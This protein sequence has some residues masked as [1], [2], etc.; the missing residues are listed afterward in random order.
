MAADPILPDT[1]AAEKGLA[2]SQLEPSAASEQLQQAELARPS[3]ILTQGL[4]HSD[5]PLTAPPTNDDTRPELP[6]KSESTF[7]DTSIDGSIRIWDRRVAMPVATILPQGSPW[8]TGACWS[9][10]GNFFYA[11]RKTCSVDEYSIHHLGS[12][13]N[14]PN[15][16]F[17]FQPGSGPVYAVRA[18]PNKKHLV[19]AS[20]D[21][22]R[23]YD[24]VQPDNSK[25]SR[26]PFNIVPGHRGG[27]VSAIHIDPSCRFML[28]ASGTRGWEGNPTEVLLGY[29]IGVQDEKG[30]WH[31]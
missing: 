5:E 29:E 9:P 14:E 23:I 6:P 27:V 22:L 1:G 20:N 17:K 24:L 16:S 21:I 25:H 15:R 26:V 10:D 12:K 2:D 3:S 31:K 11:G 8:V 30:I 7:L 19:C 13:R 18:M 4:P 28:S